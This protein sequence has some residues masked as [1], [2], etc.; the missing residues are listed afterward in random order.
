MSPS[1]SINSLF[2]VVGFFSFYL[3]SSVAIIV[4]L[5]QPLLMVIFVIQQVFASKKNLSLLPP[6]TLLV[7]LFQVHQKTRYFE[8]SSLL[9]IKKSDKRSLYNSLL[10]S[11][12]T[13]KYS[14]I[15]KSNKVYLLL[16]I[17]ND[18]VLWLIQIYK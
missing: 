11:R 18:N 5:K 10:L 3:S 2:F 4:T 1:L 8:N 13:C 17:V 12:R 9:C 14:R 15:P 7:F 16:L 6:Q